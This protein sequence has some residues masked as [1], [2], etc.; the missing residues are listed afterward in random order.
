MDPIHAQAAR[1][2]L[3]RNHV[4]LGLPARIPIHA[5]SVSRYAVRSSSTITRISVTRLNIR[6]FVINVSQTDTIAEAT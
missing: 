1:H 2:R 3:N 6:S 5:P 4:V